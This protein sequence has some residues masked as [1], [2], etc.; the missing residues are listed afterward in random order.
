MLKPISHPKPVIKAPKSGE[1]D[2]VMRREGDMD[3][4]IMHSLEYHSA[5][6]DDVTNYVMQQTKGDQVTFK[7]VIPKAGTYSL[8]MTAEIDG[9]KL[10]LY[11]YV[12]KADYCKKDARPFPASVSNHGID[13]V[14]LIEPQSG[15]LLEDTKV[16][17]KVKVPGA[18]KV[19]V[20]DTDLKGKKDVWS[21]DVTT[22]EAGNNISISTITEKHPDGV[23][24]F[25]F[26]VSINH[27]LVYM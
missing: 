11:Q 2:I 15:V 5:L 23:E 21:G 12:I 13:G 16:K 3:I 17:F 10:A 9:Q 22:G 4:P 8:N 19:W 26:Q 27:Y 6:A 24:L 18:E 20:K 1:F 7:C 14:E 25:T